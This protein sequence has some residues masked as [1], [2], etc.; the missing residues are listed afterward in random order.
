[1]VDGFE[2]NAPAFP[3][4]FLAAPPSRVRHKVSVPRRHDDEKAAR[5]RTREVRLKVAG[6]DDGK[7]AR[8]FAQCWSHGARRRKL[9]SKRSLQTA[10]ACSLERDTPE[11]SEGPHTPCRF[12]PA[13]IYSIISASSPT[14]SK[15][16][17]PGHPAR[18]VPRAVRSWDAPQYR[19]DPGASR[20]ISIASGKP[21]PRNT[22]NVAPKSAE[23]R[24]VAS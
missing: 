13:I 9:G 16:G 20:E 6:H 18:K 10:P 15:C 21:S 19:F 12:F 7:S 2:E 5:R 4:Y 11:I 22:R 17:D 14:V 23:S 8:Q 3:I 1:M 24:S